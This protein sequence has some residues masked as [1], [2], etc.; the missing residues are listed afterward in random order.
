MALQPLSTLS[1]IGAAICTER[2]FLQYAESGYLLLVVGLSFKVSA[3]PFH[4]W[5][6]DVYTGSPNL[7]TAFM[8]TVVKTAGFAAFFTLFATAFAPAASVWTLPVSIIAG[9]TMTLANTTALFQDNFKRMMAYSSIAHAGYLLLAIL[10]VQNTS[11]D[12]ALMFDLLSY[13][14]ATICAFAVY[15]VVSE[16]KEDETFAAFNGLGKIASVPG[17][18]AGYFSTVAGR[19]TSFPGFFW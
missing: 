13:S 16:Q 12:R 6:P 8:A 5:A 4:F 7:V 3:A 11:A 15:I 9:L 17:A 2:F 1:A 19:C 14:I 18:G 10:S